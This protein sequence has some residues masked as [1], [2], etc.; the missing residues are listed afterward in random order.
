MKPL[1]GADEDVNVEELRY[2]LQNIVEVTAWHGDYGDAICPGGHTDAR[3]YLKGKPY[4][5]CHHERCQA[6][7][8]A[9][10]AETLEVF[11]DF[12]A[13]RN[14]KIELT[15]EEKRGQWSNLWVKMQEKRASVL[16]PQSG[17]S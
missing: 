16:R 13:G 11:V 7:V 2:L 3:L 15:K 5:Y 10:N 9:V 1:H 4:L 8:A 6:E 12:C 14:I 17:A